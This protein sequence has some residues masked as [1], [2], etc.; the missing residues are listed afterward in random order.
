VEAEGGGEAGRFFAAVA[1][2]LLFGVRRGVF[3]HSWLV[4]VVWIYLWKLA[5]GF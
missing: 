1:L 4:A 2:A 3:H 5:G